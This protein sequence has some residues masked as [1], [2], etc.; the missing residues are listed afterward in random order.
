MNK[1]S[2]ITYSVETDR[3]TADI[4]TTET[5]STDDSGDGICAVFNCDNT[6]QY[7]TTPTSSEYAST[8]TID[9]D[10][11]SNTTDS[12]EL[13]TETS[14]QSSANKSQDCHCLVAILTLVVGVWLRLQTELYSSGS[15]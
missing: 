8:P 14:T 15:K 4:R 11:T 3:E 5:V 9:P 12:T 2:E 1:S 7:V 6:I 10:A 13:P